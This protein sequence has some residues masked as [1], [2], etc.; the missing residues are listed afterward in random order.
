MK[1]FWLESGETTFALEPR[2]IVIGRSKEC[3]MVISDTAVSR[4]HARLHVDGTSVAVEDLGSSN[5]TFVNAAR[6][7]GKH[8]LSDGDRLQIGPADLVLRS[9]VLSFRRTLNPTPETMPRIKVLMHLGANFGE[10]DVETTEERHT[11]D[12][13]G[14]VADKMLALGRGDDAER[15]LNNALVELLSRARDGRAANLPQHVFPKAAE[16]AVR[17]AEATGRAKWVD[18]SIH[19]FSSL[20]RP[21]PAAVVDQLYET[22]RGVSGIDVPAFRSYVEVVRQL[23]DL[24]PAERFVAQRLSGLTSIVAAASR[25]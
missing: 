16:Y 9:E 8:P 18:Y 4:R 6:I 22:V 24:T 13:L 15:I 20:K 14:A 2:S 1:R 7:Q 23:R 21:L 25:P 11:I 10:S 17:L 12:M 3:Y 19:L 5:G